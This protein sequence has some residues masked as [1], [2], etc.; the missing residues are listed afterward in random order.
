MGKFGPSEVLKNNLTE[1][2]ICKRNSLSSENAM[3]EIAVSK[4]NEENKTDPVS[5][6]DLEAF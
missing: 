2:S 6:R 5:R 4:Q 3:N 1:P